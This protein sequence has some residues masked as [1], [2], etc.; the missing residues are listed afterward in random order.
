VCGI[1]GELRFDGQPSDPAVVAAMRD[2]LTHRGP[3]E[4]GLH[5]SPSGR[6]AIGFRRLRIID[7]TPNA[8]QPM[9]NEDG[10]IHVVLNGEIY[11]FQQLRRG[12]VARGHRFRS[13]SDTE[14]IVHLYEEKGAGVFADLDGMFAI[15]IWD[16]RE[17]R[18]T[19]ARDR[20]GKKPLFVYRSSGLLAFASEVK[21]FFAHP[22]IDIQPDRD[23]LPYYFLHGYVP[24]PST[25]YRNVSQLEPATAMTIDADGRTA[26][27]RYWQLQYPAASAV[28][29]VSPGD[30]TAGV[31]ERLTR[32]VER[33]LVSD[34][35]L[36]AFLSGGLDS[37]IVVGVMSQLTGSRVK[38]FSI[39]FENEP[40]YDETAYARIAADRFATDH[41]EFRVPP[42]SPDLLEKLV[43]HHDGPFADSSAVPTFIV[44]K[45]TRESVTVVLTGDG[46][47]ELFAG[48]DRFRAA[49]LAEHIP[50]PVASIANALTTTLPA[51]S[52]ERHWLARMQR[53]ARGAGLPIEERLTRWSG[54]FADDLD[55]LLLPEFVRSV[56]PV[57]PLR[58]IASERQWMAGRSPLSRTLHLNFTTYLP[59]DLLVKTDR[60]T[61]AN[62]LEA[63]APFLDRELVEY[64]SALP[65]KYKLAGNRTKAVLRDAFADLVPAEIAQRGKMGF[66]V[67]LAAWFRGGPPSRLGASAGQGLRDALTGVLLSPTARYREFLSGRHVESLVAR[68]LAGDGDRAHQLF[69]VLSFELWLRLLPE[70][71]KV[72]LRPIRYNNQP[73]SLS[74]L[75]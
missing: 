26:Q 49:V 40:A 31:R 39:G 10:S 56:A 24:A 5:A 38:T 71:T 51:P 19:I 29:A 55:S 23:A 45:L 37:T 16:E 74:T 7:L 75:P 47:D 21:A 11:N 13:E 48:Y 44:S 42:A 61:M 1:C 54:V 25:F 43:W 9:A 30:A 8:S 34:V 35:P 36:G 59:G 28:N 15:A 53:F 64:V 27:R 58:Y 46:G 6:A 66:G 63:R 12:L 32:A 69:A 3:D 20:V 62:A 60:M 14:V 18:L 52:S 2:Q 65:D 33:R 72:R 4:D 73:C 41:T 50:A 17:R 67:P 22:D 70:W 68:H 57:D